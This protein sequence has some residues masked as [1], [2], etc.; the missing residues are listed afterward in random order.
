M[1]SFFP[2]VGAWSLALVAV[3]HAQQPDTEFFEKKIRPVLAT[4]CYACHSSKLKSPMGGLLL[5][6][7]EGLAK[8][9]VPGK[10]GASPILRA[11]GYRDLQLKMPP[12]GK[13]PDP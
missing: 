7:R 1:S 9:V 5:D 13:L 6:T 3:A 2:R 12:T 4:N 10:P 8:V 11:L